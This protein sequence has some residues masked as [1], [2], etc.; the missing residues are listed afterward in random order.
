MGTKCYMLLCKIRQGLAG[1]APESAISRA[2]CNIFRDVYVLLTI[3][4]SARN[5]GRHREARACQL[6]STECSS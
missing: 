1:A 3:E 2:G 4:L 5:L 6:N